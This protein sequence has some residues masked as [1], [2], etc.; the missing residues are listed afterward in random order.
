MRTALLLLLLLFAS[1]KLLS[2]EIVFEYNQGLG[3]YSMAGLKSLNETVKGSLPFNTEIVNDFPM[4]WYF[5]PGISYRIKLFEIGCIYQYQSTGSRI[6]VKDYS[7]NYHFDTQVSSHAPGIKLGYII[8]DND[9]LRLK[10]Y[11]LGG[12]ILSKLKLDEY[13]EVNEEALINEEFSFKGQNYY[14]EPGVAISHP[15]RF[16]ELAINMGYNLQFGDQAFYFQD[17]KDA[18]LRN[19]K[20]GRPIKP[21]WTGIRIGLSVIYSIKTKK[22]N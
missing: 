20:T 7:G 15:F 18:T 19:T 21:G 17:I 6:S 1:N 4:Y 11:A 2:Q 13:L 16:I 9:L 8:L 10:I 14:I 12:I 3:S 5:R 22:N